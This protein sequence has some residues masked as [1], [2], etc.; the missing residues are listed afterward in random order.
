MVSGHGALRDRRPR[1]PPGMMQQEENAFRLQ[2]HQKQG[3][4]SL[5]RPGPCKPTAS[6]NQ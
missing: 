2:C 3:Y 1:R 5:A 4:G 6:N